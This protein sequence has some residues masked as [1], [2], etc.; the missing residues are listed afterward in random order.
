MNPFNLPNR[1]IKKNLDYFL[2]YYLERSRHR[3]LRHTILSYCH[4]YQRPLG[5]NGVIVDVTFFIQYL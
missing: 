3:Q 4:A 5:Q 1:Y 2:D